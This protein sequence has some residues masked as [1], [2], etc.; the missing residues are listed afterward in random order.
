MSF[1]VFAG[2]LRLHVEGVMGLS[3]MSTGYEF[4]SPDNTANGH[5]QGVVLVD[6]KDPNDLPEHRQRPVRASFD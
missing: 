1:L 5:R 6:G 4:I 2:N 3:A